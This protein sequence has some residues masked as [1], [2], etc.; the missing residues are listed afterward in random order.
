[1]IGSHGCVLATSIPPNIERFDRDREVGRDYQRLCIQSWIQAGFRIVSLNSPDEVPGLAA[2]HPEVQ[3]VAVE[4]DAS[5]RWGRK[6]PL[7][8][9]MLGAL[10]AQAEPIAGIINADICLEPGMDW[11][12][13]ISPEVG[14]AI[15]VA[16]RRDVQ[17]M[18][19]SEGEI[20]VYGYDLFFF[21]TKAIPPSD[22]CPFALGMPWWDYWLP[23]A[24]KFG[25]SRS[26]LL[27]SPL[28]SHLKHPK[29]FDDR[30]WQLTGQEFADHV[31]SAA[32]ANPKSVSQDLVPLV[33]LCR[34]I[35]AGLPAIR[36]KSFLASL[37]NKLRGATDAGPDLSREL[38]RLA[39]ACVAAISHKV[40]H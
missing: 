14:G 37:G 13:A 1:M 5:V 22:N 15:I 11:L 34:R 26:K 18:G 12:G 31:V 20:H 9:D 10:Q 28:L 23:L 2:R 19:T 24:F 38:E 32:A 3:F 29:N 36:E 17:A 39:V 40:V 4:R 6:T 8:A 30:V 27:A 16:N 33:A 21:E 7:L 35:T 25:G